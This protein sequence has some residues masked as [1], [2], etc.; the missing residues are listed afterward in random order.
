[1][2]SIGDMTVAASVPSRREGAS[3]AASRQGN[4]RRR[5]RGGGLWLALLLA[6]LGLLPAV[7]SA[8]I[9]PSL[10]VSPT[11]ISGGETATATLSVAG[12]HPGATIAIEL[13]GT[14]V[15]DAD[16]SITDLAGSEM[17]SERVGNTMTVFVTSG[18]NQQ[19]TAT[20][21]A[22]ANA[23]PAGESRTLRMTVVDC[24][25]GEDDF[26]VTCPTGASAEL[27]LR[28]AEPEPDPEPDPLDL[29]GL[30]GLS[31]NQRTMG[32]TITTV[33]QGLDG[34]SNRN[35]GEQDLFEQCTAADQRA[36]GGTAAAGLD[37]VVAR[38]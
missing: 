4:C 35:P 18:F 36:M 6:S 32:G 16:Y 38:V 21:T 24:V 5:H 23:V 13:G 9:S 7:A 31:G 27:T 25:E 3:G 22:I 10:A 29:A 2:T 33:C 11:S 15:L 19:G 14:A 8:Q 12:E 1:M 34:R 20:I 28:G 37:R 17:D 26:A 30:P